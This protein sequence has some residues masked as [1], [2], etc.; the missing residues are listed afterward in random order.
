MNPRV[1]LVGAVIVLAGCA[2]TPADRIENG[3]AAFATWPREVQTKIR[4]G[5]VA[6]GFT[7]AQVRMALGEPDRVLTRM[8]DKGTE[9]MWSYES[10]KPRISI[11]IGMGGGGGRTF[12]GGA[13]T[14]AGGGPYPDEILRVIFSEGVV[15]AVE[16]V[17]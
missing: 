12:V 10:H 17:K 6:I 3:R 1:F 9:E 4:A 14:V 7:P 15:E 16:Q 2:G 13:T 8:T 11:G 5:E